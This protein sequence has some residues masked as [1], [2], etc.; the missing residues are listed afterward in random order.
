MKSEWIEHDGKKILFAK[1]CDFGTDLDSLKIEV[2]QCDQ[3]ALAQAP[4][5]LLLLVDVRKTTETPEI[6]AFIKKSAAKTKNNMKKIA[7]LGVSGVR[8]V[9][10]KAIALFI[11]I[12]IQAFEDIESAKEWLV[13]D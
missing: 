7:A 12:P 1:Y 5:S 9:I 4:H 2:E 11:D 6:K 8:L 10:M 13:K 3:I